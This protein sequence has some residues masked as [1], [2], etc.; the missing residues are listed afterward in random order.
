MKRL[1]PVL[2]SFFATCAVLLSAPIAFG[3]QTQLSLV[4]IITALRSKKATIAEKNEILAAGVKQRGVTFALNPDLEKELR[5]AGADD[6]LIGSIRAKSPVV[7][8]DPTP[9]PKIEPTPAPVAIPK[10]QDAT[11]FQN[12]ANASFVMGEFDAAINDYTKAIEL[13]G[14]DPMMFFSRGM[15]HFN[16]KNFNP[17]IADFDKVIELDPTESMAYFNRGVALEN[18]GNFEKSLADLKKAVELDSENEPAKNA[19]TRL[20][21]KMPK[22]V[23]SVPTKEVAKTQPVDER[24]KTVQPG[25]SNEL[26]SAG[27]LRELALKLAVPTYPQ[28]ERQNRTE[29]VVTVQV[30]LDEEGKVVT[31]KAT[32]GP[33]GLRGASEEA[34][35]RSKFKPV[36]VEGKAV[37]AT[38]TVVY[39]FKLS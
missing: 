18:V 24:P 31:A 4:D 6:Q 3:Q 22:P 9:Q 30:T 11:Y 5:T 7:K 21:A 16:K 20:Q 39:N 15:A 10:P 1:S 19:L 37:K 25:S 8:A 34:A 38:G 17:A 13:N 23:Q 2:L 27:S 33:K 14:K 29:G 12:R 36:T 26:Y 35:K 28:I 32:N